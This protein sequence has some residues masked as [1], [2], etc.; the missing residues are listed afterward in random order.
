LDAVLI[1]ASGKANSDLKGI[2]TVF[3][4]PLILQELHRYEPNSVGAEK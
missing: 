4:F 1:T 3:D 2:L